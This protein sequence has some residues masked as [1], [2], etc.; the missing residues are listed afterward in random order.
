MNLRIWFV[1]SFVLW[2]SAC[3]FQLRGAYELPAHLQT[4]QLQSSDPYSAI[5]RQISKSLQHGGVQLV[6]TSA[7][8]LPLIRIGD[9]KLERSNLSL[10]RDGRVAE[11]RLLYQLTVTLIQPE[12]PEKIIHLQVQRD[13]LDNPSEALAKRREMELLLSE[14]R[15][16]LAAQLL[17]QLAAH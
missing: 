16:Q 10:Y 8:R 2:L 7:Q 6:A 17:V 11:Y 12:Q 1:T 4:I 5:T 3:G 14:M 13:Y 9:E 15:Q